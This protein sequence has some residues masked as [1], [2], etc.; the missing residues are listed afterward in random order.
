MTSADRESLSVLIMARN[1][2]DNLEALLPDVARVL[3]DAGYA[4]WGKESRD[5]DRGAL[6]GHP[7]DQP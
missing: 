5:Q 3:G 7:G 1:E 4:I 6:R 2:A